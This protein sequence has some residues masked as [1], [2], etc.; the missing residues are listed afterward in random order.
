[1]EAGN[2]GGSS[3]APPPDVGADAAPTP[4]EQQQQ[5]QSLWGPRV[6]D[7]I[8]LKVAIAY[9]DLHPGNQAA[10]ES[11]CKP[12]VGP[13]D[14]YVQDAVRTLALEHE[15]MVKCRPHTQFT[16]RS[17][18]FGKVRTREDCVAPC[19]IMEFAAGGSLG[20][21]IRKLRDWYGHGTTAEATQRVIARIGHALKALHSHVSAIHRDVKA[22]NILIKTPLPHTDKLSCEEVLDLVDSV[23]LG[24]FGLG[25][26]VPSGDLAETVVYTKGHEAPDVFAGTTYDWRV[27]AWALG[28]LVPECALGDVPFPELRNEEP[29]DRAALMSYEELERSQ[30]GKE[31]FQWMF[32]YTFRTFLQRTLARESKYRDSVVSLYRRDD[33]IAFLQLP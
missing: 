18:A 17:H 22:D 16:L 30:Q 23:V 6:G 5:Q 29:E 28:L 4:S 26:I 31:T 25:R 12:S 11:I 9:K 2:L 21:L 27:D 3:A 13:E 20:S 14:T 19:V 15:L 7:T 1:M 8:A 32:S 33:M 24:D 10:Y